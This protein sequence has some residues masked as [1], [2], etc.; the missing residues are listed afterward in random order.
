M[1]GVLLRRWSWVGR[2]TGRRRCEGWRPRWEETRS[3]KPRGARDCQ[4]TPTDQ[5]RKDSPT[6]FG[7]SMT[8]PTPWFR[9]P[10]LQN[11]ETRHFCCFKSPDLW[12]FQQSKET[13]HTDSQAWGFIGVHKKPVVFIWRA[14]FGI[15]FHKNYL[16]HLLGLW[17]CSWESRALSPTSSSCDI[18]SAFLRSWK[19]H[20]R[21]ILWENESMKKLDFFFLIGNTHFTTFLCSDGLSYAHSFSKPHHAPAVCQWLN[22]HGLWPP[23]ASSLGT[24]SHHSPTPPTSMLP[25]HLSRPPPQVMPA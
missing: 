17:C 6:G 15:C 13:N 7:G 25:L 11:S 20:F 22:S 12:Y 18:G 4:Q 8:L 1:T 14:A 3:C 2:H 16:S 5:G 19:C 9:T 21:Q 10:R 23:W 24:A